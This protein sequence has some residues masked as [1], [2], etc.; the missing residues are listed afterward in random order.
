M[1]SFK[2]LLRYIRRG[3]GGMEGVGDCDSMDDFGE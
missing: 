1:K 3:R 2:R